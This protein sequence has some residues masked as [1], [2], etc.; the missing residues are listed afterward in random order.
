M[1]ICAIAA[2]LIALVS[3]P[4]RAES[5]SS[6]PCGRAQMTR[7]H[8]EIG[9]A[10]R[11]SV[12]FAAPSDEICPGD[13]LTTGAESRLRWMAPDGTELE[14]PP[15]SKVTVENGER[16]RLL[17]G[18]IL[19]ARPVGKA[20]SAFEVAGP[21]A[22]AWIA[23]GK[24]SV[25]IAAR[26]T[27]EPSLRAIAFRGSAALAFDGGRKLELKLRESAGP[28]LDARPRRLSQRAARGEE[29]RLRGGPLPKQRPIRDK[30][31]PS[32]AVSK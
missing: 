29:L 23:D 32:S 20:P 30:G 11:G 10:E 9:S 22:A 18:A 24:A 15:D 8:A 14:L 19:V 26:K 2:T 5:A 21:G 25:E 4:T 3:R 16:V 28:E 6:P 27:G 13:S 7:C 17:Q 12:G 31:C 1:A